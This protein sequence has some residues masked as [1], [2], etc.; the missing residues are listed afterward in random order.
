VDDDFLRKSIQVTDERI[1]M[2]LPSAH[3]LAWAWDRQFGAQFDASTRVARIA[4]LVSVANSFLAQLD[5]EMRKGK[6]IN[7]PPR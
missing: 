7:H 3:T 6:G 4:A 5:Y 2:V 1:E